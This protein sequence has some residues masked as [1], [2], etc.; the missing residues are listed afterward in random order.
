[1]AEAATDYE[2]LRKLSEEQA[3]LQSAIDDAMTRWEH[4]SER[5]QS[6]SIT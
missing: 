5:Q 6:P 4:L 1:M 3:A 2:R